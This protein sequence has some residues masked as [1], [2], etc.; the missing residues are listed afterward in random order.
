ML[1]M[2]GE[3]AKVAA[4]PPPPPAPVAIEPP[5]PAALEKCA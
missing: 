5:V 1:R 4:P 2:R 3:P